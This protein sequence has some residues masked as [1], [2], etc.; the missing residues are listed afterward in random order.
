MSRNQNSDEPSME[1]LLASIRKAIH[2][3]EGLARAR[4]KDERP[5]PQMPGGPAV[6]PS[7]AG[8]IASLKEQIHQELGFDRPRAPYPAPQEGMKMAP[9]M[10]PAA[11]NAP[12]PGFAPRSHAAPAAQPG[13]FTSMFANQQPSP[14]PSAGRGAP[15][16]RRTDKR[17]G[18]TSPQAAD[19]VAGAFERLARPQVAPKAASS[20]LGRLQAERSFDEITR[21]MLQPMLK[22][23]LDRH[24]PALVERLVRAEIERIAR[25]GR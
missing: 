16:L 25:R 11:P 9:P 13:S 21:E 1:E 18:L 14:G 15:S 7:L 20:T 17:D 10:R 24:L 19:S 3:E 4:T 23:W 6:V 8:D 12:Q 22:Q 2:E 5:I